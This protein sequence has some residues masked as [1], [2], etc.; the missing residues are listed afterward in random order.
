[1]NIKSAH[2][3]VGI[4]IS[5]V[6]VFLKEKSYNDEE[7]FADKEYFA[8]ISRDPKAMMSFSVNHSAITKYDECA[9]KC[10]LRNLTK[11]CLV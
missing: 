6:Y 4:L 2:A 9:L 8:F 3:M 10:N 5:I 11:K 1:M 7:Q